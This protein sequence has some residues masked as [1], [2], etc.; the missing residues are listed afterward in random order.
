MLHQKR[1]VTTKEKRR[2]KKLSPVVTNSRNRLAKRPKFESLDMSKVRISTQSNNHKQT[3]RHFFRT[4][5]CTS[6]Q[7]NSKDTKHRPLNYIE[8]QMPNNLTTLNSLDRMPLTEFM[9]TPYRTRAPSIVNSPQK[10]QANFIASSFDLSNQQETQVPPPFLNDS[11]ITQE[12]FKL[13]NITLSSQDSESHII[14][15]NLRKRKLFARDKRV[16]FLGNDLYS[17]LYSSPSDAQQRDIYSIQSN[18]L[19]PAIQHSIQSPPLTVE[20]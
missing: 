10:Y 18:R 5:R 2:P 8:N 16:K 4:C 11:F 14:T 3:S 15:N 1:M 12:N 17:K 19:P 7:K 9:T 13:P 20:H 6:I